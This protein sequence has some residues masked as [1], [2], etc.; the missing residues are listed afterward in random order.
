MLPYVRC[1]AAEGRWTSPI[2]A[3]H[4]QRRL[5]GGY[6]VCGGGA[7]G[8]EGVV[9]AAQEEDGGGGEADEEVEP[10]QRTPPPKASTASCPLRMPEQAIRRVGARRWAAGPRPA[11]TP[12]SA[13]R[14]PERTAATSAVWSA[15]LWSA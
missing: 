13:G 2:T 4:L 5:C 6:R 7:P 1:P 15:S 11:H 14:R 12:V 9:V 8:G 3:A 10:G